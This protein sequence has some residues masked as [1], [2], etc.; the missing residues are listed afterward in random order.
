MGEQEFETPV[1]ADLIQRLRRKV[2]NLQ[3]LPAV[4]MQAL[5][6]AQDPDCSIAELTRIVEQDLKLSTF[7]LRVAN[8]ALYA[9]PTAVA[10]LPQAISWLGLRQC[11][12]FILS[13]G[14]D[15]LS[16]RLT[17]DLRSRRELLT[18]H[19]LLTG[20]IAAR[21]NR[22]LSLGFEGE[23]FTAG[24]LHDMGRTLLAIAVPERFRSIDPLDF[25]EA[26]DI[27]RR[28]HSMIGTSHTNFGEWFAQWN[29]LPEA[30]VV[31]IRHHHS[32]G[33]APAHTRLAALTAV[34]DQIANHIQRAEPA[35]AV[36]WGT[37][38]ALRLLEESGAA[39]AVLRVRQ[40]METLTVE[41]P[42]AADSILAA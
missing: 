10:S 21:I 9:G 37:N 6:L 11:R 32:P 7:V 39:H 14:M 27:E 26:D 15:S 30:L 18:R 24:L 19:G 31:A 2:Y 8:S 38:S 28:E 35:D 25:H 4:A 22:Q 17:G 12:E 13:A 23:E 41:C 20:L 34:A 29:E 16:A 1:P 40:A 33:R 36:D 5:E 3:M 42:N